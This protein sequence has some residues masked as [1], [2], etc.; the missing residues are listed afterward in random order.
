MTT[1]NTVNNWDSW[2][3]VRNTINT[4][5]SNLNL[6]KVEKE[7]WK[8]LSTNDY[9]TIEKNKL[10][11]LWDNTFLL[12]RAN[13]TWSQA[14]STITWLQTVLDNKQNILTLTTL[15]TWA[16]TL[17]NN[18]LNIPV[19]SWSWWGA[20]FQYISWDPYS[21]TNLANALNSKQNTLN[22]SS[23]LAT[24]NWINLLYWWSLN[25]SSNISNIISS[26]IS[27][28]N[29]NI[30]D[31]LYLNEDW[32]V[33]KTNRQ[34]GKFIWIA[35]QTISSSQ[36]INVVTYWEYIWSWFTIWN[37]YI[38]DGFK[39][40]TGFTWRKEVK[41]VWSWWYI[42]CIGWKPWTINT[43]KIEAY[44]IANDIWSTLTSIWFTAK[45]QWG[46][47]VY[48][49][50]IYYLLWET[51]WL[52]N[53]VNIFNISNSTWSTSVNNNNISKRLV[54]SCLDNSTWLIYILWWYNGLTLNKLD[55]YNANTDTWDYSKNS[56]THNR[57]WATAKLVNWIIYLFW[58][59]N[60]TSYVTSIEKYN[61][62][63]NQWSIDTNKY[64]WL[65]STSEV[66]WDDIYIFWN[67]KIY[68]YDTLKSDLSFF[69]DM[70]YN[71]NSFGSWIYN[72]IVYIIWWQN[73]NWTS[74]VNLNETFNWYAN[75]KIWIA[76]S[77]T[78]LFLWN[79][80][81]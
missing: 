10:S 21:N 18:V 19:S 63:T 28:E 51:S 74:L 53:T 66:I 55:I 26:F 5:F 15:W 7:V 45:S 20:D 52:D 4:N 39:S 46:I 57:Y 71:R 56:F 36:S 38:Q 37:Y 61:I 50:K 72:W 77:T 60:W 81:L 68:K 22:W 1:I 54:C 25:I 75:K 73:Y 42:Y 76:T 31:R 12:N 40:V 64:T 9:T 80:I 49:W 62:A 78:R 32:K 23:I 58:W 35:N 48:N 27:W 8:W 79:N 65:D 59:H 3:N 11:A 33:Y 70:L 13:H 24:I 6:N 43:N 41:C 44:D 47:E 29:I 34:I 30:W 69:S 16:A 17:I 14:I 67:W 2:L